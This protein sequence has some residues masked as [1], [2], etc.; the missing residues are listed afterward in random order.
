MFAIISS[1]IAGICMAFQ[2][3][4]NTRLN[5]KIGI[6]ETNLIVQIIGLIL[7]III[8]STFGSGNI[9][10]IKNCNKLY[11]SGGILGVIII[12]TVIH[13]I[14]SLGPTFSTELILIAQLV[15]ASLIDAFG[16][17]DTQ[18]TRF[19]APKIIGVLMM[20]VGIVIFKY[21]R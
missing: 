1:L 10:N 6:W 4:F 16:L 9:K 3:V 2:G 17:F 12:Y 5:E 14:G 18:R 8:V 20:I 19:D 15:S 11:L 7:T 13:G 21:K